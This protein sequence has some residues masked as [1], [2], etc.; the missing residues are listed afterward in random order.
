MKVFLRIIKKEIALSNRYI[1]NNHNLNKIKMKVKVTNKF[2]ITIKVN[3][4]N[5]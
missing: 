1:H 4:E 5:N 3:C 2:K